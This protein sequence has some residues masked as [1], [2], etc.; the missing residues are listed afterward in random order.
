M[1]TARISRGFTLFEVIIALMV[2][3]VA[4]IA[5]VGAINGI[6]DASVEA[7]RQ[8]EVTARLE[9]LITEFARRPWP[10]GTGDLSMEKKLNENGVEY[11]IKISKAEL[12]NREGLPLSEMYSVITT[13]RWKDGSRQEETGAET[14]MYAPLY[15]PAL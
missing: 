15:A 5:L 8:R 9:S 7:R 3:S 4:V 13:A 10:K 11:F 1:K 6:G 2:F 14:M 12:T